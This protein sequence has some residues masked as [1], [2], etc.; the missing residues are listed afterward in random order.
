MV[1][2]L[3]LR[4]ADIFPDA[5]R[6]VS[7]RHFV[8]LRLGDILLKIQKESVRGALATQIADDLRLFVDAIE[9]EFGNKQPADVSAPMPK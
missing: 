7:I 2:A 5:A 1:E 4:Q 6:S 9:E 3:R 8:H